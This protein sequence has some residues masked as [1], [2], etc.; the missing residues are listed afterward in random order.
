MW[1]V[2]IALSRPYTFLVLALLILFLSPVVILRT[3]TDIF[4]N[5]NIPVVSVA[6][7][8]TGLNPEDLEARITTPFEKVLTTLV[9]NIEHLESTTYNGVA[10]TK[11]FLQPGTSVDTANSQVVAASQF[12]LRFLPPAS[13]PPE[14]INFSASSVPIVQMGLSGKGMS[15]QQLNDIGLQFVRTQIITVPGAVVPLPYG[16]KQRQIMINLNQNLMQ[17]KHITSNDVLKAV[18]AQNLILPSGTAKIGESELDVRLNSAP[19]TIPELG[20]LPVKQIAATTLYLRDVATVSDGSALQTNVVRQDG[21]RGVLLSILKAGNASTLN[22]VRGVRELLPRIAAIIPPEV[23]MTFLGDQS[24]FVR[25]S[26]SSVVREGVIAAALTGLM[27]LLFLGNWRG[28]LIIAVSIP[29]SILSS[30]LVLSLLHETINIDQYHDAWRPGAGG[31]YPRGRRHGGDRKHRAQPAH[32]KGTARRN[33]G[34]RAANRDAGFRRD[35]LYLHRLPPDLPARR[36]RASPFRA[37]R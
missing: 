31:R 1:I 26:I 20:D 5:I 19:R 33:S 12:V 25:A 36:S 14:I 29:L 23:K 4:P 35:S 18:N 11:I 37:A 34:R 15:E 22:V 32:E 21:R 3:P 28:T 16:G 24:T 10:V 6:W 2:K 27:I 9:D 30:I 13:Q 8:Y 17:S 7:T